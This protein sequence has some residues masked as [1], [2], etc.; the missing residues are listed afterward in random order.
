MTS[1]VGIGFLRLG[2][3]IAFPS[4]V[5]SDRGF[6][7]RGLTLYISSPKEVSMDPACRWCRGKPCL[8]QKR[9]YKMPS[10]IDSTAPDVYSKNVNQY[11]KGVTRESMKPGDAKKG[12]RPKEESATG[13]ERDS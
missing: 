11:G 12:K 9:R 6:S 7:G 5:V 4:G 13:G 10:K 1:L 2:S 3:G 8:K